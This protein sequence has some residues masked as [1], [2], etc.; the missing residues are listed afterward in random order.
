VRRIFPRYLL[1]FAVIV[2]W[3]CSAPSTVKKKAI[4]DI[5]SLVNAQ[6]E[7]LLANKIQLTKLVEIEGSKDEAHYTPDSVQWNNELEIFRQLD[8]INKAAF[9]D[10]YVVNELPDT[11]SNLSIKEVKASRPVPVSVIRFYYLRDQRDLRKIEALI[12]EE[13]P[14]YSNDRR[15]LMEFERIGNKSFMNRFR[16]EGRQKMVMDDSARFVIAGEVAP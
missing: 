2:Q 8:Q 15:V 6:V 4:Y 3:S 11:N 7:Y 16:I 10:A 5:D 13:N 14:L 9:S 1:A 12:T